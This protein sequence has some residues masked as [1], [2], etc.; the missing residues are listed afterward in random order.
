MPLSFQAEPDG[1][2]TTCE[3]AYETQRGKMRSI[4]TWKIE[5]SDQWTLFNLNYAPE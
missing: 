3:T 4:V 1:S 2:Y 5:K